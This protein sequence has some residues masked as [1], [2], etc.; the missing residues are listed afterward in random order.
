MAKDPSQIVPK[1]IIITVEVNRHPCCALL[2]AGSLGDFISG[3]LVDQ[4]K[5]KKTELNKP[6]MLNLAVQSSRSKIKSTVTIE[7]GYNKIRESRT[8]DVIN[9]NSYDLILGTPWL[10]QH[11]VKIGFN[12]I[13]VEIG[14]IVALLMKKSTSTKFLASAITPILSDLEAARDELHR[15]SDH[16]CKDVNETDLPPFWAINHTIPLID[17]NKI[18]SWHPS[19]CPE[20]FRGQWAEKC[21]AYLRSGQWQITSAENTVPMLLIPKPKKK[22]GEPP[23]LCT[24][25]DLCER[26]FN[27]RKLTSPLPDMEGILRRIASKPF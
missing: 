18:Y 16:L 22:P 8:F 17:E 19:H 27:T 25:I 15:A 26:N 21:D 23:E 13:M 14:S 1:P 4:L 20:V 12:P 5:I 2:D 7:M 24:V 11:K 9:I 6:V 3:F 10:Y